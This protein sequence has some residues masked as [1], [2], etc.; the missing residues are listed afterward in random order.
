MSQ[1]LSIPCCPPREATQLRGSQAGGH[2]LFP[3]R[4][5]WS[6]SQGRSSQTGLC[7]E[8]TEQG[9]G[10]VRAVGKV[11]ADVPQ[12]VLRPQLA[13][14]LKAE[15]RFCPCSVSSQ[16]SVTDLPPPSVPIRDAAP[17]TD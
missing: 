1:A 15:D 4:A 6:T 9:S 7:R 2:I 5:F 8:G 11:H 13:A 10:Q 12:P 14:S 16:M 17:R 3:S